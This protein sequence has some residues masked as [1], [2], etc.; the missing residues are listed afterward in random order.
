MAYQAL[1]GQFLGQYELRELLGVGGMG[2][3]WRPISRCLF[4]FTADNH[5]DE[6]SKEND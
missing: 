5:D 4:C 1:I 3:V 2:A 6:R